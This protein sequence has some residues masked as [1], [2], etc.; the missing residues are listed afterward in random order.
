METEESLIEKV[1]SGNDAAFG[2][3][4]FTY[5]Q[6]LSAYARTILKDSDEAEDMVQQVFIN[7]WEKRQALVVHSSL[8][9]LLYRSVHNACLNRIKQRQVRSAHA[10]ETIQLHRHNLATA[11]H[12]QHKELQQTIEAAFGQL[13]E[14]CAR[15]FRMSRFEQLKYHEI[16]DRLGLSVKTVENQMGKALKLM[17]EHL[18]DYLPGLII[19]LSLYY[20]D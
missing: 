17:R 6:P 1:R 14:Q 10:L 11:D 19:I 2:Q 9:S 16:A 3:V 13:P 15:I 18:K 8:K 20:R 5:Y 7:I 12:L 4:F